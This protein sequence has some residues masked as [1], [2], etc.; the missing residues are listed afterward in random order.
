MFTIKKYTDK[1]ICYELKL[2]KTI[3]KSNKFINNAEIRR[4]NC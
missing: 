2:S 1:L 3:S 4:I